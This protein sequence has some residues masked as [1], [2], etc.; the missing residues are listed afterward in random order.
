MKLN[1]EEL[2]A[3]TIELAQWPSTRGKHEQ[4]ILSIV[5]QCNI[6]QTA[7]VAKG[8]TDILHIERVWGSDCMTHKPLQ[9]WTDILYIPTS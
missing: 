4:L 1:N 9:N 2:H 5:M 3:N 7:I 8:I 6:C